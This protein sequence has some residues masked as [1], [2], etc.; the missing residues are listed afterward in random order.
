MGT[1][2][3]VTNNNYLKIFIIKLKGPR[4]QDSG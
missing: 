1:Y 3:T 4:Q 2:G